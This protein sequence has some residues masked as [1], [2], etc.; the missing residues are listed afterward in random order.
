MQ[1]VLRPLCLSLSHTYTCIM[2]H[3]TSVPYILYNIY[4]KPL[5]QSP[6]PHFPNPFPYCHLSHQLRSLSPSSGIFLLYYQNLVTTLLIL[7]TMARSRPDITLQKLPSTLQSTWFVYH[8]HS[9]NTCR[10]VERGHTGN[11]TFFLS[12][13]FVVV[14]NKKGK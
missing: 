5:H 11:W 7:F 2:H 10:T 8:L 3:Q 14:H 1:G 13:F 9:Q 12:G 6:K 4:K